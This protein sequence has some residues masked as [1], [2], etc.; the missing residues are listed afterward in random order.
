MIRT[1]RIKLHGGYVN[2]GRAKGI[3]G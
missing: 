2:K 1:D 3:K